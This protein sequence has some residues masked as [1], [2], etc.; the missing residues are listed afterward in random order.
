MET[1]VFD[2]FADELEKISTGVGEHVAELAGLGTL[3]APHAYSAVTGKKPSHKTERNVELAGLGI[4]AAP[5]AI[6]LGKHLLKKA[7]PVTPQMM[8]S[9]DAHQAFLKQQPAAPKAAPKLTHPANMQRANMLADFTPPGA[10][11]A[12]AAAKAVSHAAPKMAPL[13]RVVSGAKPAAGRL[14]GLLRRAV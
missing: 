10:F 3:A 7:A 11:H 2:S 1:A 5:S 8:A 4:L 9:Y 6:N 12:P 13:S 14:A